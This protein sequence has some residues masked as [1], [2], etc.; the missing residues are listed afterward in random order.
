MAF[1]AEDGTGLTGANSLARVT[2]AD[3]Y[4]LEIDNSVWGALTL[5]KK[6]QNLVKA[7]RFFEQRYKLYGKRK[8]ATQ[9]TEF[10]RTGLLDEFANKLDD[11]VPLR[12]AYGIVELALIVQTEPLFFTPE[13]PSGTSGPIVSKKEK[14]GPLEEEIKYQTGA[15]NTTVKVERVLPNAE[16]WF[17]GY[18]VPDDTYAKKVYR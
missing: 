12:I 18:V 13:L 11:Q 17:R 7:T 1:L 9:G 16:R 5:K 4:F 8:L 14:V 10:P 15:E 2:I 6:Q 3:I